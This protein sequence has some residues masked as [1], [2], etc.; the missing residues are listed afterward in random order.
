MNA[1]DW[2]RPSSL[3]SRHPGL[4]HCHVL[5]F[6]AV[7]GLC[8]LRDFLFRF[9]TQVWI[10]LAWVSLYTF[11]CAG[12]ESLDKSVRCMLCARGSLLPVGRCFEC[13]S[14]SC[15]LHFNETI[16]DDRISHPAHLLDTSSLAG[17]P[18]VCNTLYMFTQNHSLP[19]MLISNSH[20]PQKRQILR[21]SVWCP[22]TIYHCCQEDARYAAEG[23]Y[24]GRSFMAGKL[25]RGCMPCCV[26][27]A[28][29]AVFCSS[30]LLWTTLIIWDLTCHPIQHNSTHL[31]NPAA[32][33]GSYGYG[34]PYQG[35]S[36]T[37]YGY[38]YDQSQFMAG[39]AAG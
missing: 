8:F 7:G 27:H 17:L 1:R 32:D 31:T 38:G 30:R 29:I 16:W 15:L 13:P 3:A 37:G 34:E 11:V 5:H 4:F 20:S 14:S 10:I 24:A 25:Q 6:L 23:G 2:T 39:G 35:A 19:H 22:G 21:V 33:Y 28:F 9:S 18:C 12:T 36:F 26:Q